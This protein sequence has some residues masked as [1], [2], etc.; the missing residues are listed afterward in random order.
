V[1]SKPRAIFALPGGQMYPPVS[2]GELLS[3][4]YQVS[5]KTITEEVSS[6]LELHPEIPGVILVSDNNI[7]SMIP[8]SKMFERLGHRYGV[9][10]FLQKP[11]IELQETLETT[12][13]KISSNTRINTAANIA[14][15]RQAKNIYDPLVMEYDDG[16]F[17]QLDMHVL[18]MAQ[19][20]VMENMN[21][22]ISS[23][24]RIEQSIK[25]DIPLDTSLDMIIDA[26]KR[27]IPY[28]HAAILLKPS[29]WIETFSHHELLYELSESLNSHPLIKEIFD[30]GNYIH[31]EDTHLSPSWKG[32]EFISETSV[33]MGLPIASRGNL[34][35]ILSLSRVTNTPFSKNE[36]D[37]AKTFSEFLSI[38]IN[39]TA[40]NYEEDHYVNMIK[41]KFIS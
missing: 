39:K 15:G 18:L 32:M 11:I 33:W 4:N 27:T 5:I 9:E 25:A 41:R 20:L 29:R 6:H 16:S 2:V 34:D 14:I 36:I 31:I 37:M 23:M 24:N 3:H 13:F 35:G 10:L 28:H 17:R 40:E 38:A 30:T 26:I 19:S 21:N 12:I 8:R 22:I 1:K 7:H